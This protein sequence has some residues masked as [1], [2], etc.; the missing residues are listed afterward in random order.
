M[1]NLTRI[2]PNVIHC[3]CPHSTPLV[4]MNLHFI[5]V[6]SIDAERQMCTPVLTCA[7]ENVFTYSINV[8]K[9]QSVCLVTVI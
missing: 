8:G 1:C 5:F 6:T 9:S 3:P 4:I 7:L 2:L